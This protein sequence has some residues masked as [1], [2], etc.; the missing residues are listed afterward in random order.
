LLLERDSLN[1]WKLVTLEVVAL[2]LWEA[3]A[4]SGTD[5]WDEVVTR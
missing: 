5:D 1:S 2:T 3:D 4:E